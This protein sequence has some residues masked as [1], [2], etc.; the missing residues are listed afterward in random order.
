MAPAKISIHI[1]EPNICSYV[2]TVESPLFC[3]PLQG[4]DNTY[5]TLTSEMP[6]LQDHEREYEPKTFSSVPERNEAEQ[7]S[8]ATLFEHLS[9]EERD[10]RN[11]EAAQ[12]NEEEHETSSEQKKTPFRIEV[13]EQLVQDDDVVFRKVIMEK[14]DEKYQSHEASEARFE[15]NKANTGDEENDENKQSQEKI[16]L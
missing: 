2:L 8:E 6:A 11:H 3:E 7:I 13:L 14:T 9:D 16:E 4:M 1:N 5:G 15:E 10:S 12:K